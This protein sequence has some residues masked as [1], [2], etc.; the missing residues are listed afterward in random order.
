MHK[1]KRMVGEPL[2]LS[3]FDLIK[4]FASEPGAK[5]LDYLDDDSEE[6]VRSFI[7]IQI[8][9]QQKDNL[10]CLALRLKNT[11]TW[12][13]F[14]SLTKSYEDKSDKRVYTNIGLL[15]KYRRQGFGREIKEFLL[16]LAFN[17]YE[18]TE[19][20]SEVYD[21]NTAALEL[22]KKIGMK[23]IDYLQT[24]GTDERKYFLLSF[25]KD[26][27]IQEAQSQGL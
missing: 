26:K 2:N 7:K 8:Q 4:Q 24:S 9:S 11:P 22:N 20:F 27:F 19:V 21:H 16:E 10:P 12:I 15:K 14:A 13:G 5:N 23:V 6:T 25:T 17:F 18:L 3:H 1:T